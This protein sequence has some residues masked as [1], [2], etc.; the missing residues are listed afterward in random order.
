MLIDLEVALGIRNVGMATEGAAA[1]GHV[2]SR[3]QRLLHAERAVSLI[4]VSRL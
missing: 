1:R 4:Q 2:A 3:L